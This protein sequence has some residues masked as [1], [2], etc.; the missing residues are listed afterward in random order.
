MGT[1]PR[2]CPVCFEPITEDNRGVRT[3]AWRR[4]SPRHQW[5]PAWKLGASDE[6]VCQQCAAVKGAGR[7]G[8][9]NLVSVT[10]Q[11]FIEELRP[12]E[13]EQCSVPLL[14]APSKRRKRDTCSTSCRARLYKTETSVP[15]AVTRCEGCGQ[16][17][18]GRSDRRHCSPACRQRAY[19][20]RNRL[21]QLGQTPE[22]AARADLFSALSNDQFEQVLEQA[23]RDEDASAEHV[24]TLARE[25]FRQP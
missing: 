10:L 7:D 6:L 23:Q 18:H 19:R 4:R 14:L 11:A 5:I 22:D 3:V 8:K 20:R 15:P 16:D 1:V 13:C 25:L 9:H 2:E 21:V 24:A 17:M 12:A